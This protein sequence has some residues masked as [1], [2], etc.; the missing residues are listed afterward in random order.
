MTPKRVGQECRPDIFQVM[1]IALIFLAGR[2]H[3]FDSANEN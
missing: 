1:I 2:C 3:R